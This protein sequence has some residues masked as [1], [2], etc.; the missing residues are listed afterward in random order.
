LG[1]RPEFRWWILAATVAAVLIGIS[2]LALDRPNVVWTAGV[3]SCPLC[4]SE[5]HA[6]ASRCPTCREEFEWNDPSDDESP[7]SPWSL[8]ALEDAWLRERVT[9]LGKPQAATRVSEALQLDA[10]AARLYL[11][12]VGWGRCGWCGGTG[13]DLSVR[14]P[15]LEP[16]PACLGR[17]RC[18]ACDGDRRIRIGDDAAERAFQRYR[19]QALDVSRRIPLDRQ[20]AE[21]RRLAEEFLRV[22]HGTEQATR[23]WFWP[24]WD[25]EAPD[26]PLIVQRSRERLNRVL[27][28]LARE[29]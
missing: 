9:A 18:V 23:I 11:E 2:F 28:A 20:R 4:R 14:A 13:R 22:H 26:H 17:A 6:N 1:V 3:P 21:V 10:D 5:V 15:T 16:C 27:D 7:L 8:S 25:A 12:Q 19:A 24:E 29:P